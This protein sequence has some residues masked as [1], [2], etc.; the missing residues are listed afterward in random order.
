MCD[1]ERDGRSSSHPPAGREVS[2]LC[3]Q[4]L[5]N[6]LVIQSQ[7]EVMLVNELWEKKQV[8]LLLLDF[9]VYAYI[10]S[11]TVQVFY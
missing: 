4:H 7:V 8:A 1:G 2:K 9:A 6:H 11:L 3:P 10:C 5:Y